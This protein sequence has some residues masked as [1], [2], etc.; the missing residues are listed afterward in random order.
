MVFFVF[1]M[2]FIGSI[3]EDK[4]IGQELI[5]GSALKDHIKKKKPDH[6]IV[7]VGEEDLG[8]QEI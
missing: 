4:V 5:E 6:D 8:E 3:I 2:Y 1:I 7:R